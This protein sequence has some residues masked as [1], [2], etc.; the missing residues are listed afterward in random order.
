MDTDQILER[1]QAVPVPTALAFAMVCVGAVLL[2]HAGSPL[3]EA[4]SLRVRG[5]RSSIPARSETSQSFP[6]QLQSQ[7]DT[8]SSVSTNICR[9]LPGVMLES[10]NRISVDDRR[11][12]GDLRGSSRTRSASLGPIASNSFV[13]TANAISQTSGFD[14]KLVSFD[15]LEQSLLP[16]D[17]IQARDANKKFQN[18][19]A[20]QL[21][22][23]ASRQQV[24]QRTKVVYLHPGEVKNIRVRF[25]ETVATKITKIRVANRSVCE[26]VVS[27]SNKLQLIAIGL[28][29]TEIDAWAQLEFPGSGE[30]KRQYRIKVIGLSERFQSDFGNTLEVL[31]RSIRKV[32]PE[33]DVHLQVDMDSIVVQGQCD[34]E[35]SSSRI[36]AMVRKVL[37]V[38]VRDHLRMKDESGL[39][40]RDGFMPTDCGCNTR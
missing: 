30:I 17:T 34:T 1:F 16:T 13:A 29:K 22:V 20:T 36:I 37:L 24:V 32:Y 31:E 25:D 15:E 11:T 3:G 19:L 26:A 6:L 39:L 4:P 21:D 7:L 8:E 35:Q 23:D 38:P 40:M 2:F 12:V 28:G 33:C 18:F 14:S 10:V 5:T 27:G 9:R